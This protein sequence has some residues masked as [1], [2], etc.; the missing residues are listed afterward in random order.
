MSSKSKIEH[1]FIIFANLFKLC[2]YLSS[3]VIQVKEVGLRSKQDACRL[4]KDAKHDV[5]RGL[6]IKLL[7]PVNVVVSLV[8]MC[9]TCDKVSRLQRII[10]VSPYLGER[11]LF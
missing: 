11:S 4:G 1:Y 6:L 3:I 10:R 5:V 8:N 2:L 7:E 9:R